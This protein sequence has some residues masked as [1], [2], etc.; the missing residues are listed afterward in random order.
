MP[1]FGF[2]LILQ[3]CNLETCGSLLF[4]VSPLKQPLT[5]DKTQNGLS[6][7]LDLFHFISSEKKQ[8]GADIQKCQSLESTWT[9]YIYMD[10]CRHYCYHNQQYHYHYHCHC[11]CSIKVIIIFSAPKE[12]SS[13]S[14]R[15]CHKPGRE[16]CWKLYQTKHMLTR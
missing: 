9:F 15:L 5:K 6:Q 1:N 11:H 7:I 4:L 12:E 2:I 16:V 3:N 13:H 14:D 8:N 10:H